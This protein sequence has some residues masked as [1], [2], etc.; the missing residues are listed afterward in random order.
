M[1][2]E[3]AAAP[4]RGQVKITDIAAMRLEDGFCLIRVDTDA[5]ISGYGECGDNDGN[6][7][8]ALIETHAKGGGRL[9]HLKLIGKDPLAIRVH[10]HNM[11]HV[12]PQRRR[13][14]QVASGIDMALWDLA[15]KL[16]GASVA[17]LLGGPFRDDILLYSHCPQG[18]FTD[19]VAWRD[20]AAE[21]K[22]DPHGFKAFKVDIHSCLGLHMQQYVPSLSPGDVRKVRRSY[23]LA[24]EN[25]GEDIDII[26]H[27]HN[28]LDTPSAIAVAEAVEAIKPLYYEDP[29]QPGFSENWLALRRT[30][31]LPILTGEN[32]EFAE[33]ALPFLTTQAVDCLQPDIVNS[34]GITGTKM[35]A[36]LAAL[37]RTPITLHN[38]SGLL[39]NMAS[40]QLA[41]AIFNCPRIECTRRA[42]ANRW[43]AVNP[44]EIADGRMKISTA[45]GLGVTLDEDWL[46]G[47]RFAGEPYWH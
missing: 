26:V 11:F 17:T 31:R 15:G 41:A 45:P 33:G 8:R 39:L 7:V 13:E 37:Y 34:G 6:L 21:L 23:E 40:Q 20:R 1:T 10:H 44:L 16:L 18:D 4:V 46:K 22:S 43:A 42:T 32:I 27:C 3:T 36:D 24:R 9:P 30:T 47:H 5:G 35:I 19:P 14:M 12:F 28:E 38:V 2:L 25:L 29:L